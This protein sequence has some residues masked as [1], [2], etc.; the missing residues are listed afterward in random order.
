[1]NSRQ[2]VQALVNEC[3]AM[4]HVIGWVGNGVMVVR[5]KIEQAKGTFDKLVAQGDITVEHNPQ[6]AAAVRC[7]DLGIMPRQDLCLGARAEINQYL[8][9]LRAQLRDGDGG[10]RAFHRERG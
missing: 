5:E 10:E 1:M 7:L 3:E 9:P 8:L 6:T 2:E 4:R